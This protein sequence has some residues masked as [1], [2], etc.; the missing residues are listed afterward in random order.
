MIIFNRNQC[1]AI[2]SN[3]MKKINYCSGLRN[4]KPYI[5]FNL[6][7]LNINTANNGYNQLLL[8]YNNLQID[9][10]LKTTYPQRL[11]KY[12]KYNVT[13][14]KDWMPHNIVIKHDNTNV[15]KQNVEDDRNQSRIFKLIDT[16][17]VY[18]DIMMDLICNISNIVKHIEPTVKKLD[19]HIHQVRLLTYPD[20]STSNSPEGLHRDGSDYIVSALVL[21]K[22]NVKGGE[23]IVKDYR[24]NESYRTILQQNEGLFQED[25]ELWHYV[26]PINCEDDNYV[27]YRDILGFDID[28]IERD[29]QNYCDN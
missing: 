11:R 10:Y 1:N 2:T 9:P 27:G 14:N 12:A 25:K 8:S 13:F 20:I 24:K 7:E 17:I 26:T 29:S 23:S 3:I 4:Y 15:Y 19:V 16:N 22:F 5:K 18:S 6:N 21:N 28:I